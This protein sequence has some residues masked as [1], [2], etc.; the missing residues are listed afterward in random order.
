MK[1]KRSWK[2]ILLMILSI[3]SIIAGVITLF[4]GVFGM[5]ITPQ[6]TAQTGSD[7]ESATIGLV[8]IIAV[9][10]LVLLEGIFGILASV[11]PAKTMPFIVVSSIALILCGIA[12][13]KS[14][15]GGLFNMIFSGQGKLEP[16]LIVITIL[17]AIMDAFGN[18]IRFDYKK[19]SSTVPICR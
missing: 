18:M 8:I 1:Q 5:M 2:Q 14:T 19:G 15:G 3:I 9:G 10:V 12:V 17:T 4:V 16:S 6:L 11:N 7:T 13:A